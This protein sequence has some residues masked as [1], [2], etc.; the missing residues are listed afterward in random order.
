MKFIRLLALALLL[1]TSQPMAGQVLVPPDLVAWWQAEGNA[2]DAVGGSHGT[3]IG[4]AGFAPGV[5]GQ[6]FVLDGVDGWASLANTATMDFGTGD[7]TIELWM[8]PDSVSRLQDLI[9]KVCCGFFPSNRL[10]LIEI[11]AGTLRFLIRGTAANQNDLIVPVNLTPGVWH[12]VAAVRQGDTSLLY[13]N[14][15]LIGSQTAG[16]AADSGSGGSAAFG[17]QVP[18]HPLFPTDTRF[19]G[20]LLDEISLYRRAL[21]EQE[22][23]QI[24]AAGSAGKVLAIPV[25]IDI[26]PG[27]LPN[28]INL[29]SN[30]TVPVAILSSASLDAA[31]IDP[32]TVAL[33]G[34]AV[35]LRGRGTPS[36]TS[37]ET[38]CGTSWFTSA[39]R[40]SSSRE[41]TSKPSSRGRPLPASRFA[42]RIR[43]GSSLRD[44]RARTKRGNGMQERS[45]LGD[46]IRVSRD[47]PDETPTEKE[48]KR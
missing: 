23:Q 33:A 12:H 21:T 45:R 1:A 20:G 41:Q 42:A 34:A 18:I 15:G 48:R 47:R 43:C 46:R 16:V 29:G 25:A 37:T 36:R 9:L 17:R 6:A 22:I 19:F 11:D 10:Y 31:T 27:S 40:R 44:S 35:E 32:T 3:L 5:V 38:G 30:G 13:V 14:G 39:P 28:S 4:G 8:N 7:F 24:T 2:S 26:K